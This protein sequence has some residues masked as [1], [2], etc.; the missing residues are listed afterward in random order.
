MKK[1]DIYNHIFPQSYFQ[2]MMEVAGNHKDLG[3][4]VR[5]VPM[6]VNLEERFKVMDLF[7]DYVQILS[8]PAPPPE[9]LATPDVSPELSNTP[10]NGLSFR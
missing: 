7:E 4:R 3:K 10:R 6:L 2:K 1:I 8:V 9:V 5:N